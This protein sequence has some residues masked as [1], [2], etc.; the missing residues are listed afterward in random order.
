MGIEKMSRMPLVHFD[1]AFGEY[2]PGAASKSKMTSILSE[3]P[4]QISWSVYPLEF[5]FAE[6][7]QTLVARGPR[8]SRAKDIYDLSILSKKADDIEKLKAAVA[9]VFEKRKTEFPSDWPQFTS[10][11]DVT[12]LRT[13][14]PSVHLKN[15]QS[16]DEVYFEVSSFLA[17]IFG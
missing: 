14:W 15:S 16:F 8:N 5:I 17:D 2:L 4:S 12:L 10:S 3:Q 13:A 1:V 11:L 6:K 7:L 9:T